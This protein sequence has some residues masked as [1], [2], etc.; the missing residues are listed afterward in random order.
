M[1]RKT[2]LFV[3]VVIASLLTSCAVAQ[4]NPGSIY[5]LQ[6]WATV[7]GIQSAINGEAHTVIMTTKDLFVFIWPVGENGWAFACTGK[8]TDWRT[9]VELA[10]GKGT[11][12]NA[13][14][15]G[16]IIKS[17][18]ESGWERVLP[19]A[20]PDS[21]R[22]LFMQSAHAALSV[23]RGM[24]SIVVFPV[25]PDALPDGVGGVAY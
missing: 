8:L 14:D 25:V 22:T 6:P 3:I 9:F 23:A 5:A 19:A 2:S 11:L 17:L 10:G 4:V 7:H 24:I 15:I 12:V 13:K 18:E 20:V 21:F 1:V 16:G